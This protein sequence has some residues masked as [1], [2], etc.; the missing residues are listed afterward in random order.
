MKPKLSEKNKYLL[1]GNGSVG[2]AAHISHTQTVSPILVVEEPEKETGITISSEHL[3]SNIDITKFSEP[4][5]SG[6]EM[7][8]QRR[9]NNR[10]K[11]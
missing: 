10:K 2:I 11:I 3:I 5:L 6:R 1:I 4:Q 9:K 8:R 7:R